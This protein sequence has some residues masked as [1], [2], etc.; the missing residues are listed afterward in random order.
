M[1][2]PKDPARDARSPAT[3]TVLSQAIGRTRFIVLLAVV[4]VLLVA[5]SLFLQGTLQAAYTIYE[6]W[7]D[8][9]RGDLGGQ[10]VAVQSLEIVSIMLKAVVFYLIGV[11]LYSLFI[12]PLNLTSALGVESLSDLEHK[13]VS[14]VIVI[15]G[16]TFLEHFVTW[17]KPLDT[18]M[19]GGAL[20]LVAGALV[21]FQR[22]S[23]G[24]EDMGS[25]P[26]ETRLRAR[27]EL[28]EKDHEERAI[29]EGEVR[30]VQAQ[31][32]E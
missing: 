8:V 16:V 14:V 11:G 13:V 21:L 10:A 24:R 31:E 29:P 32:G 18:L 20:A 3:G 5:L 2:D 22:F 17:E 28:F 6:T 7:S 4:S 25:L 15:L 19:F 12:A 26:P 23:A 30:R 27:R 9:L 1:P